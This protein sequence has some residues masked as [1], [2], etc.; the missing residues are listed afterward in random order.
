M[1]IDIWN[2]KLSER[3]DQFCSSF[4]VLGVIILVVLC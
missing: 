2:V 4:G 3:F 1:C